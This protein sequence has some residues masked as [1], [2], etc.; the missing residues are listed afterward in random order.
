M[1]SRTTMISVILNEPWEAAHFQQHWSAEEL[2]LYPVGTD[3]AAVAPTTQVLSVFIHTPVRAADLARLPELK[4]IA[5]RATGYDH[6]DLDYCQAHGIAVCNVP[7]YGER[8][9]AE[10]AMG[11]LLAAA[12]HIVPS[13]LR[14]QREWRGDVQGLRG[15]DLHGKTLGLIGT[16]RIG[17]NMGQMTT[18]FG[19]RLLAYDLAPNLE[20]AQSVGATYVP[21]DT[22]YREA[23]VLSFHAPLTASTRH[24]F[25]YDSLALIKPGLIL[26]NSSRGGLVQNT[27]LLAG[28][29]Q[30]LIRAAGLDVIENEHLIGKNEP[31]SDIALM[32][33]ILAHPAVIASAHNAYNSVEAIERIISTTIHNMQLFTQQREIAYRLC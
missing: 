2:T 5:I 30:G 33:Q 10:Y 21:L 4:L 28:L 8:T 29:E 1:E 6:V 23:D 9:V 31:A 27:A 3:A 22:L 20:W 24:L 7:A 17:R 19:M 32:Q 13:T 18:G 14:L 15:V 25:N 11:L 16:G 26:I 12:R